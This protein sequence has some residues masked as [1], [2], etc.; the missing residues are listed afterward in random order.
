MS[1]TT[2]QKINVKCPHCGKLLKAPPSWIGKSLKCPGCAKTFAAKAA[3]PSAAMMHPST[4]PPKFDFVE[5]R[6]GKKEVHAFLLGMGLAVVAAIIST[7]LWFAVGSALNKEA[8]WFAFIAAMLIGGGMFL[9]YRRAD[10]AMGMLAGMLTLGVFIGAR[11]IIYQSIASNLLSEFAVDEFEGPKAVAFQKEYEKQIDS[12][13]EYTE[14]EDPDGEKAEADIAKL[15]LKI[16]KEIETLSE[17]EARKKII[18]ADLDNVDSTIGS[19]EMEKAVHE[20]GY[21]LDSIPG[22]A[23][24]EASKTADER[25][26]KLKPAEKK[27]RYYA[28][29]KAELLETL[30]ADLAKLDSVRSTQANADAPEDPTLIAEKKKLVEKMSVEEMIV[31]D[32]VVDAELW[33][34]SLD[35]MKDTGAKVATGVSFL[36]PKSIMIALSSIGL[37]YTFATGGKFKD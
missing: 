33:Q 23:Y 30:P 21:S 37:A 17:T 36:N 19:Q 27:E 32:E 18:D 34:A 29:R 2:D 22:Y 28:I 11:Y 7:L 4:A 9:G 3:A 24:E 5:D 10:V 1:G 13:P 20:R 31:Q 14:E 6:K 35:S 16:V 15:R 12:L 8:N 25:V 26:A